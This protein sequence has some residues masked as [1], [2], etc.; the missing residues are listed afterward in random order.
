M[1]Y[2]LIDFIKTAAAQDH[3]KFISNRNHDLYKDFA[4]FLGY[5][6]HHTPNSRPNNEPKLLPFKWSINRRCKVKNVRVMFFPHMSAHALKDVAYERGL[7]FPNGWEISEVIT[8]LL[9]IRRE[10]NEFQ[11]IADPNW[12][13]VTK[14][15]LNSLFNIIARYDRDSLGVH[16]I[17]EK[18]KIRMTEAVRKIS[19]TAVVLHAYCDEVIYHGGQV[20]I[21]G[22]HHETHKLAIFDDCYGVAYGDI[23]S[24]SGIFPIR[25]DMKEW[26]PSKNFPDSEEVQYKKASEGIEKRID[27]FKASL[28]EYMT[29]EYIEDTFDCSSLSL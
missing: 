20:D 4:V 5:D 8:T 9:D 18:M 23:A 3:Q 12:R 11:H 21:P 24:T 22:V 2:E 10:F 7:H 14:Y 28:E 17:N 29:A 16:Y 15:L 27:R 6:R 1:K 26:E 13:I 19:E 25:F